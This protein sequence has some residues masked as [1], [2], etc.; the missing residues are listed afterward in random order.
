MALIEL[1]GDLA[2]KFGKDSFIKNLEPI[3]MTYLTSTAAAVREVGIAKIRQM[4]AN[5]K[6]EWVV[7]SFIPKILECYNVD[8][9]GFNYRM[10]C[11]MSLSSVMP[12]LQKDQI[13]E[14]IVPTVVAATT[15]KVPNVQ[16]C[17]CRIIKQ[18]KA[19]FDAGVLN[20]QIIP[21]LK[22]LMQDGDRDVAYHATL[23][24]NE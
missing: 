20:S 4:A 5:F 1:I 23:A 9:Q 11:L 7:A 2:L 21:K 17:V 19:L 16:F 13:T 24:F 14:K 15:D 3:F 12:V 22:D 6:S 8:K 18:N 10:A